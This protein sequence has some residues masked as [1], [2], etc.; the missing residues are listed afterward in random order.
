MRYYLIAGEASGDL[1]GS[2]LMKGLIAEDPA[3]EFRFFGG[4]LM[5]A[6]GG[7]PVRH[8]KSTAVMGIV[9]VISRLGAIRRNMAECRRD[10]LEYGPDVLILIDYPGFNLKMARFAHKHGIP[11]FYYIAPKLWARGE[12][13]IRK[14]RSYVDELF[15]IFPFEKKY[16]RKLGVEVHY[17]GNPLIESI[18]D[19]KSI[20]PERQKFIERHSLDDSHSIALL[21]GSRK[22]EISFLLPRMVALERLLKQDMLLQDYQLLLAAAP[23]VDLQ[24]YRSLIPAD[25][26]IRIVSGDTYGV[27]S[28][29]DA[30]VICSGTASL[31][32]ALIGTPQVVCYGFNRITYLIARLLVRVKYISLANLILDKFIFKEFVQDDASPRMI[33]DE[34]L[35]LLTDNEYRNAMK[36]DYTALRE[37]LGGSGAS[38]KIARKMI[39]LL[40]EN[41]VNK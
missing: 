26:S 3:A 27:L 21:A 28:H 1:H 35:R 9:E 19:Y 32:A 33:F 11:V 16:F 6:V 36:S 29:S 17:E 31:E 24:L 13:R 37:I 15:V 8:Y 34:V 22:A 30:A 39:G 4:D 5:A 20:H 14:I 38:R 18:E 40:K 12:K 7:I 10:L 2:N 25:S 41:N 23:S